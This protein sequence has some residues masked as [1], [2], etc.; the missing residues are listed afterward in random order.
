M[1]RSRV[2]RFLII[3]TLFLLIGACAKVS[4]PS[5]GPKDRT[6]PVVLETVPEYG[7][8]N[9]KG[10]KISITFDEYVS[11]DNINEK[12][13]VSPPMKKKPRVFVKGKNV[14]AEFEEEL[15]DSTTYT[16]Y[17]LDAIRDLNEGNTMD[18]YQFVLSTG[19]VVDSLS[20]TGNVYD[21]LS[22]ETPEKTMVLLYRELADSFVVK[23]LPDYISRVDQKGYF[24]INNVK[25]G[26]YRLYALKDADNSKNY[27]LSDEDFAF[28]SSPVDITTEKNFIPV[29]KDTVKIKKEVPKLKDI[30]S[31]KE[32]KIQDTIVPQGEYPLI[33]YAASKTIHYLTSSGRPLKYQLN[34]TLS[35]PPDTMEF[36]FSIPGSGGKGYFIEKSIEKDTITV[37]LTDSILYSQSQLKTIIDYPFTDTLGITGYK[38]D[39][40]QMRFLA[41]RAG[42]GAK[43]KKPVYTFSTNVKG[44]LLKPG[45][46]LI[47][48]SATPFREPDTT[49]I[50]FYQ[51]SDSTKLKIGYSFIKDSSTTCRYYLRAD[52]KQDKKYIFIADSASFGDIYNQNS[53]STGFNLSLR[54]PDSFSKLTLNITSCKTTCI[55]QLLNKE[56]LVSESF[57]KSDAK[58]IFPMLDAGSYRLKVIYDLNGDG[59]WTTGDFDQGRQPEPVSYYPREIDLKTGWEV[60]QDW[61]IGKQ[62]YKEE[63]L[64][65]KKSTKK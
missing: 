62:L 35:L 24:R 2:E 6:P 25:P 29:I 58:V 11:L 12:F 44:G 16:F 40:I 9:F 14:I 61:D 27:N 3:S 47:F 39:T 18:D 51:P 10:E 19:R 23:H 15:M 57:I 45:Q 17:F 43:V 26:T 42:R 53:D 4:N 56:K 31:K 52:L 20:V 30:K 34:Y 50:Q 22:L 49:R 54:K 1:K 5:G 59:K 63:R 38:E 32:S 41:P 28:M 8:K 64:R 33:L 48:T 65:E 60:D 36:R 55:I 21:A 46:E 7:S 13:M 37:W